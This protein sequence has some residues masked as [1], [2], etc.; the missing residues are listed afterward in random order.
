MA[1]P[2]GRIMNAGTS[3][4]G[5]TCT[6]EEIL[7]AA[8]AF[9]YLGLAELADLTRRLVHGDV[10]TAREQQHNRAFYGL[11]LALHPAFEHRYETAPDDFDPVSPPPRGSQSQ[12]D[13]TQPPD[14][15]P[16]A[17]PGTIT[18]HELDN[19]CILGTGCAR[20]TQGVIEHERAILHRDAGCE[21]CPSG[22]EW[23]R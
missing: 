22:P 23:A 13:R 5:D 4:V 7:R 3:A 18:V 8:D 10:R 15:G 12:P 17:C 11:E 1:K 6:A 16:V 14:H 19:T 9:D 2:H 21:L 20:L